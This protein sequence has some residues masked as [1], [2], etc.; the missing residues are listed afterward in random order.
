MFLAA[1]LGSVLVWR[2]TPLGRRMRG[3]VGLV[4]A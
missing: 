2:Y 4:E 3:E 1:W